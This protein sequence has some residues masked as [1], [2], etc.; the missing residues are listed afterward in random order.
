MLTKRLGNEGYNFA[1]VNGVPESDTMTT[2]VDIKF[3][4]DPGKRTYVNRITF[5][6]QLPYRRR[7]AAPRNA[8]DGSARRRRRI[9]SSNRACASS[10]SVISR[11]PR[12]DTPEVP[13]SDDLIDLKYSVEEQ[14]SGSIGA[15][16]GFAQGTGLVLGADL[17]QDNFLG[18]R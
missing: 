7:C 6:R 1:K 3:F 8:A 2:P 13:G 5:Q 11:R 4:V 12:V 10:A 16:I 15:S 18:T 14:P 17:Q 9:E